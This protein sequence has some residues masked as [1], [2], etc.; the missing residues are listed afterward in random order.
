MDTPR[1]KPSSDSDSE[2]SNA[3]QNDDVIIC[4]MGCT[5][6]GKSLFIKLLTKDTSVK[7][8]DSLESETS[9]VQ[10]VRFVDRTSGRTVALVDTPGFDD[11]RKGITDTVVLKKITSFLLKQYD[12]KR[13]LNGLVYLHRITDTRFGG[14]SKINLRMFQNLCGPEAYKNVVVLTTFWDQISSP[15][16]G[17]KREME[18]KDNFLNG[19]FGGG[20]TFMRHNRTVERAQRVLRHVLTFVPTDIQIVKEIREEG[21]SLEETAAGSVHGAEVERLIAKHRQEIE[22]IREEMNRVKE[23]TASMKRDLEELRDEHMKKIAQLESER[24]DLKNGLEEETRN[25]EVL[26]AE[27]EKEKSHHRQWL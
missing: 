18:L 27:A 23:D 20:A 25:R 8:S 22:K 7:V 24:V 14:Q 2:V 19:L 21:K 9:E 16:V 17:D 6:T 4:V 15:E 11:S 1:T 3:T 5:G 26:P 12:G 13:K 10:L